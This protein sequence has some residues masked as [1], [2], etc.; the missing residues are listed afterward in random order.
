MV[1]LTLVEV[2]EVPAAPLRSI[3]PMR[4]VP[5]LKQRIPSMGSVRLPCQC[6][7]KTAST[8]RFL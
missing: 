1:T 7:E 3:P 5:E 8:P 4:K 6:P 2:G